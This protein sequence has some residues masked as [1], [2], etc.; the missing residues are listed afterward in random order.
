MLEAFL[1]N[2]CIVEFLLVDSG[3]TGKC[4]AVFRGNN[5]SVQFK[6]RLDEYSIAPTRRI[7]EI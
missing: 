4:D 5:T 7:K 6:H 3:R 2:Y 1:Y